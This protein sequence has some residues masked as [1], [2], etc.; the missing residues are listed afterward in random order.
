M[1]WALSI[2]VMGVLAALGWLGYAEVA[3]WIQQQAW[4]SATGTL[5][6]RAMLGPQDRYWSFSAG[7]GWAFLGVLIPGL[8][9]GALAGAWLALVIGW[10]V[11]RIGAQADAET[12]VQERE[13]QATEREQKAQERI[14]AAEARDREAAEKQRQ[15]A[16][17][18]EQARQ[19]QEAARRLNHSKPTAPLPDTVGCG[20]GRAG[21]EL[22]SVWPCSRGPFGGI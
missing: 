6:D 8:A 18:A 17:Q 15:A 2:T 19:A 7:P 9:I 10:P 14:E 20:P 21:T 22:S 5:N 3:G 16:Q 11:L 1:K 12:T 13:R 4:V